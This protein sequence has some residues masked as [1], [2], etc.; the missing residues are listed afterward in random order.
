MGQ[1]VYHTDVNKAFRCID[2]VEF[3][4]VNIKYL[5]MLNKTNITLKNIMHLKS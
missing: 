2:E 1:F 5:E 4:I 3:I